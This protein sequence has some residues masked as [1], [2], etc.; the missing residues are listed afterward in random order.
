MRRSGI[1]TRAVGFSAL[2]ALATVPATAGPGKKDRARAAIAEARGKIDAGEKVGVSTQAPELQVRARAALASAEELL[3]RGKKDAAI[4]D[5]RHA[6]EFADMAIVAADKQK[7]E[8]ARDRRLDAEA[9]ADAAHQAAADATGRAESA[10]Q[11]AA[12]ANVRADS[13]QQAAVAA[14]AQAEALRNAPAPTSTTVA[15]VEKEVVRTPAA[16]RRTVTV[17]R[18]APVRHTTHRVV[19]K[20]ARVVEKTTTTVTTQPN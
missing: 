2:L 14:A 11:A 9:S 12:A 4:A 19:R 20:P 15:T 5:A 13:A 18:A 6:G 3:A 10:E 16:A 1:F 17:R 8:V 7:A